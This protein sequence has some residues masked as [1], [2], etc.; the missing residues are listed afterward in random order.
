MTKN[1]AKRENAMIVFGWRLETFE[2][3]ES[4]DEKNKARESVIIGSES[5]L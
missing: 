1:Q 5:C 3:L 4:E 2:N